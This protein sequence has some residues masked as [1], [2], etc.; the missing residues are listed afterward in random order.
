MYG[1]AKKLPY[2]SEG[3]RTSP[4]L[5]DRYLALTKRQPTLS[6]DTSS[7]RGTLTLF[8]D[9]AQ[10]VF[11]VTQSDRYVDR[12]DP[13]YAPLVSQVYRCLDLT[14]LPEYSREYYAGE[15]AV[16]LKEVLDRTKF[17]P[18]EAIPG[19]ENLQATDAVEP[20]ARWQVP[21]TNITIVR[22]TDGPRRGE[23]LF[24]SETV[25]RAVEMYESVKEQPYR[26]DGPPRVSRIT[27][28]VSLVSGQSERC[29]PRRVP[30][31]ILSASQVRLGDLADAGFVVRCRR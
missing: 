1:A 30:A 16:C 10:E 28:L 11:E 26:T 31:K 7:P 14:E 19:P 15:A 13:T 24:N 12:L 23:Y 9:K 8:L 5:R 6:A 4:G 27:R 29:R 20:L 25:G 3:P 21:N 22:M 18:I 17:P 2:R